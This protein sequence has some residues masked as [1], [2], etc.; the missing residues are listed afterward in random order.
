MM[1]WFTFLL[2]LGLGT[3]F[4]G[5]FK[6]GGPGD[7]RR[8]PGEPPL[9]RDT[10]VGELDDVAFGGAEVGLFRFIEVPMVPLVQ[11]G[12]VIRCFNS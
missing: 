11:H 1:G 5:T 10:W 2:G 4:V 6:R 8:P 12:G 3:T 9:A 7:S